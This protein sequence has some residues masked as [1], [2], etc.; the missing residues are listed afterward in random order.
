MAVAVRTP[1][2]PNHQCAKDRKLQYSEWPVFVVIVNVVG[3]DLESIECS[4]ITQQN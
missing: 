3:Y 4:T 2:N 1:K